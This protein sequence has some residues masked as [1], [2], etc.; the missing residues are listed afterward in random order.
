MNVCMATTT[1][2]RWAGDGQ[3]A[4][5]WG[6]ASA[7]Q[8]Q[9]VEVTVIA[10]HTPGAATRERM[11][12]V[13]VLRPAYWW[14]VAAESLRKEGGGLPIT[15]RKY[16]LARVQLPIFAAILA[17]T[18]GRVARD[19]DVVHAHWTL[20]GAAAVAARPLHRRPVLVTVQGSDVFGVTKHRLAARLT[21]A[22]LNA[23]DGVTTLT[24]ALFDA[25]A[26]I[27]V[28]T[29]AMEVIPN[30][31]NLRAFT[32]VPGGATDAP[33]ILYTGFLIPRK[34]VRYLVDALALLPSR[35]AH[36]R[37]VI[38]G[39]G[40]EE[41]NLRRQVADLGLEP[42]VEFAGFQ[43]QSVV[44]DWMQRAQLFVLPSLE[45]GQGVVMLEALASGTP[46]IASDV[47]GI[48]E[49]V[50]PEVG[51]RVPPADPPALA[52]ALTDLLSDPA[53]RAAMA[54]AARRRA[55]IHYDWDVIARRFL[56]RYAVLA[57]GGRS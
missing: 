6:L 20:A 35:L 11:E 23:A 54:A 5:V 42:R 57:Q 52:A 28:H 15:L 10:L 50:T 31:V 45:E 12:G 7:L 49:V 17:G 53:Q 44:A 37:L 24:T 25:A 9:G 34:G 13:T 33:F 56:T 14:P 41:A 18:I 32:P 38:V 51:R 19:C 47:D 21:A 46:V 29:N 36:V 8:R 30:G 16:P 55:E 26:T 40:P 22:V 3:G 43:P 2:P 27:G 4:F 1:F 39:E 48:R